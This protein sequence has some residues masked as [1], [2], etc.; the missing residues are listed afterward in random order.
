M[1]TTRGRMLVAGVI[2]VLLGAGAEAQSLGAVAEREKQRRAAVKTKAPSYGDDTLGKPTT[3]AT[4]GTADKRLPTPLT[5]S[6]GTDPDQDPEAARKAR[7]PEPS[8]DYGEGYWREQADQRRA[9]VQEAEAPVSELQKTL[10]E[11]GGPMSPPQP[12]DALR[13][14]PYR[15]L[16]IDERRVKLEADLKAAQAKLLEA[17]RALDEFEELARRKGIPPGWLRAR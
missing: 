10:R 1:G 14:D 5:A 2:G 8:I 4:A 3:P 7:N 12:G 11:E 15:L 6:A 9:A 13:H 16:T 17:R